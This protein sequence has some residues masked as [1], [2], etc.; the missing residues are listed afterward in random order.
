MTIGTVGPSALALAGDRTTPAR[1][2]RRPAPLDRGDSETRP[3]P[4]PGTD[5]GDQDAATLTLLGHRA[6]L[7]EFLGEGNEPSAPDD[8]DVDPEEL[9]AREEQAVRE[10]EARDREVR[11][12]E[13]AHVAAGGGLV[14]GGASFQYELGP[15]GKRYAVSGEVQIR[16]SDAETPEATI[17]RAQQIRRAALAPAQPS[18]QDRAVAARATQMLIEATREAASEAGE[19]RD[20]GPE[21]SDDHRPLGH[22]ESVA[23]AYERQSGPSGP[24]DGASGPTFRSTL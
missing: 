20:V 2:D 24:D 8:S 15:D 11:A 5:T 6:R 22:A 1:A 21:P 23:R 9:D 10:L 4:L 18:G 3:Q 19:A 14:Q 7:R 16:V 13:Q 17:T 12:H